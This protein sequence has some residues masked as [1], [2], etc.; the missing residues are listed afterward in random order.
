M[1]ETTINKKNISYLD[2]LQSIFTEW[3]KIKPD[4]YVHPWDMNHL[5]NW[6]IEEFDNTFL[7]V[8]KSDIALKQIILWDDIKEVID[9]IIEEYEKQD[10]LYKFWLYPDNKI[11][12]HW[13]SWC[14]KTLLAYWIAH[15]LNKKL[16]VVN[17]STIL[18]S[19]FGKTSSNI[20]NAFQ[21]ASANKWI[22]FIDE[23]DMLGKKRN[24]INDHGEVKRI[25]TAILQCLDFL[26]KNTLFIAATNHIDLVDTALLRRFSK[27]IEFT[28]PWIEQIEK[29]LLLLLNEIWIWIQPKSILK[30]ISLQYVDISY[31]EIRDKFISRIKKYILKNNTITALSKDFLNE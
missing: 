20:S 3:K 31:A 1:Q 28:I 26:D 12:F 18:D 13:P 8:F 17:L 30:K 22:L 6:K 14:W 23:F 5:V 29:Y 7:K 15:K 25:A 27:K 16:F 2:E 4:R 24:D 11:I 21:M 9:W 10:I 19:S